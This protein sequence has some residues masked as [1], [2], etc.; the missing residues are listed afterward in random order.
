MAAQRDEFPLVQVTQQR[1]A[2]TRSVTGDRTDGG[3]CP[4]SRARPDARLQH[5]HN[6]F[7]PSSTELPLF[8]DFPEDSAMY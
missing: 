7:N 5:D 8:L 1:L 4:R 3:D 2:A 6:F